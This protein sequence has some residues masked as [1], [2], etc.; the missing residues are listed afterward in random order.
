MYV[1]TSRFAKVSASSYTNMSIFHSLEVVCRS[2]GTQ[3]QVGEK[4]VFFYL[5]V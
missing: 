1:N 4:I 2:S 5:A 3:L